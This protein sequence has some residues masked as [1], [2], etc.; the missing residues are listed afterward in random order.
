LIFRSRQDT[1]R[2]YANETLYKELSRGN[3][4]LAT[5][6]KIYMAQLITRRP[7]LLDVEALDML[8]YALEGGTQM[9][10]ILKVVYGVDLF[11]PPPDGLRRGTLPV[12]PTKTVW[13][14]RTPEQWGKI[15]NEFGVTDILVQ[16]DWS[17][18]LPV[19]MKN[20]EFISYHIP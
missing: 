9:N 19:L 15:K 13:L 4:L 2:N 18:Q 5:A 20:N 12:E 17:L 7:V 14:A 8:P 16:S 1:F 3:G 10:R 11:S 6:P